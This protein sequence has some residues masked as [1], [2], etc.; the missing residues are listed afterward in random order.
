MTMAKSLINVSNNIIDEA[1]TQILLSTIHKYDENEEEDLAEPE[2]NNLED[3]LEISSDAD[4]ETQV[5]NEVSYGL[6]TSNFSVE[7]YKQL[8]YTVSNV[9]DNYSDEFN[10]GYEETGNFIDGDNEILSN[11]EAQDL[12]VCIQYANAFGTTSDIN[13]EDRRKFALYIMQNPGM[14]K[15]IEATRS[16]SRDVDYSYAA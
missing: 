14:F 5:Q 6:Q 11:P 3:Q 2:L 9:K 8:F 1:I 7:D 4:L 16:L 10:A 12:F 15:L 13:P